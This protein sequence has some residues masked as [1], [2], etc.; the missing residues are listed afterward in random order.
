MNQIRKKLKSSSGASMV[1]ALVFMLFCI[2][3]GGSVLAAA[4]A[5][6]ARIE[7]RKAN[8]QIYLSQRSAANILA[9]ELESGTGKAMLCMTVDRTSVGD[10]EYNYTFTGNGD[11]ALRMLALEA[12]AQLYV[13]STDNIDPTCKNNISYFRS[14]FNSGGEFAGTL[15]EDDR[16]V[17]VTVLAGNDELDEITAYVTCYPGTE[18]GDNYTENNDERYSLY[19]TFGDDTRLSVY[20]RAR[21][22]RHLSPD[23]VTIIWE[24][25]VIVKGDEN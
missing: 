13:S 3:V 12:A 21:V 23:T 24:N 1:I 20:M 2:F 25:P 10:R 7:K 17:L 22:D 11:N 15:S 16:K 4:S 8:E 14:S 6:G 19:V 18:D 5:N 9:S